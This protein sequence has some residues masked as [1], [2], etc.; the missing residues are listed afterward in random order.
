M[1]SGGHRSGGLF[2]GKVSQG[3]GTEKRLTHEAEDAKSGD[4]G[5][6]GRGGGGSRPDAAVD[7]CRN[8][9]ND[10]SGG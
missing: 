5:R 7:E 4:K 8:E 10:R 9:I 6:G 3:Q 2:H 1:I